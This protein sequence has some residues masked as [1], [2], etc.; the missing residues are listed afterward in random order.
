MPDYALVVEPGY[1]DHAIERDLLAGVGVELGSLPRDLAPEERFSRL[2]EAAVIFVRDTRFDAADIALCRRAKGIVRYGVGV[3]G[4]D[5]DAARRHG[6]A[7][8]NIPDYGAD[9]EV[10][11]HT[12]ALFLAVAR[13]TTTRDASVRKGIWGVGQAEPMRRI[14]GQTL[15]LFGYGRI[16]RATH[17][18]F[19]A[20]GVG[21]VLVCDPY[22]SQEQAGA[23]G[24]R[25]VDA[26]MLTSESD[27]VSIHAPGR[28]D[29]QPILSRDLIMTLRTHAIVINTAR[30]NN[31][32]ESALAEALAAGRL[33][34]AGLDVLVQEPPRPD[35][36]LLALPQVVLS[37]HTGWY[38]EATVASLQRQAGEEAVRIVSGERPRNWVNPW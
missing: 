28:H 13:R 37:D 8:A 6:I 2:A 19:A 20:F 29:G 35:N 4:I 3:D 15:G 25:L 24:V 34:G 21:N 27:I 18:R 16:G 10:A 11:D 32:D 7:V 33:A 1:R 5:L 22:L 31:I 26:A 9:I 30:G 23:A 17:R 38:S 14:A 12:L 36:P